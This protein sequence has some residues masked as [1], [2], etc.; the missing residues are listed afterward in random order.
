MFLRRARQA[1]AV[2][3]TVQLCAQRLPKNMGIRPEENQVRTPTR[4]GPAGVASLNEALQQA[5]NPP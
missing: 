3:L 5:L 2:A 1:D 4:R